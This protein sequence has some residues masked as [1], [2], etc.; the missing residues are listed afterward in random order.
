MIKQWRVSFQHGPEDVPYFGFVQLSTWCSGAV[1]VAKIRD[2]QMP[3]LALDKVGYATNADHGAGCNIHPPHKQ[4]CGERLGNSALALEYGKDIPWKSPTFAS[5]ER[6]DKGVRVEFNDVVGDLEL[7]YP[8]NYV[9]GL[10]CSKLAAGVCAWA[11]LR[12]GG[13][14]T[15][16]T[17]AVEGKALLLSGS[18]ANADATQYGYGSIPMMSV[19]D[20]QTGLPVLP[21]NMTLPT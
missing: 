4:E 7:R 2:A 16:A 18:A 6:T 20:S 21:W 8:A 15:N 14:W 12:T 5:A 19:Y 3:A 1:G 9:A 11:G 13:A 17:V 10:D